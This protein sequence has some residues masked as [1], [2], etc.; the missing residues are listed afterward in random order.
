MKR[1][2]YIA[3]TALTALAGCVKVE[4]VERPAEEVSF[5]VGQ[6]AAT[7]AASLN[8]ESITSFR[9]KGFL[10]ANGVDG[11]QDFF[12]ASGET[13]YWR[14]G[15]SM[16]T[17]TH[18]Y[19]WPKHSDSYVN[20]VSW[21][22]NGGDPTTATETSLQWIGRT[23]AASDN[24]MFADAVW[25][26]KSN[27]ANGSQ[28]NGDEVTSGVPTLFHHALSRVQIKLRATVAADPDN[29]STTY[30][31]TL[32]SAQLLGYYTTGNMRLSTTEPAGTTPA[33]SIWLGVNNATLLWYP[34]NGANTTP[35]ACIDSDMN[36]TTTAAPVLALRSFMPQSLG[37][38][39]VFNFTYTLTTRSN[40]V[41]TSSEEDIPVSIVL[42]TIRST[43]NMVINQWQPNK[44]Y[45]Y[46]IAINPIGQEILLNPIVES[47][48]T[49]GND[50][51]ATV[52]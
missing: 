49:F 8:S 19:Y 45:T 48:W 10:Y 15:S 6:Y 18:P 47:D 51:S 50:L 7:K 22:D 13:I 3:L 12:G 24:I 44:I 37:D 31:I 29:A 11:A 20:F 52:E 33:T 1:Y 28:Y 2:I 26:Y 34:S 42:N 16:W 35:L 17:P 25:H 41:I 23:I 9:S 39:V 38:G 21:Y 32:N 30:E 40:G 36:L 43:A 27:T 5:T 14:E 4:T 46:N